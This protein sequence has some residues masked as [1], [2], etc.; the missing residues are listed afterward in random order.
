MEG[1]HISH[2]FKIVQFFNSFSILLFNLQLFLYC[3]TFATYIFTQFICHHELP[4][5]KMIDTDFCVDE[6][7]LFIEDKLDKKVE[8]NHERTRYQTVTIV[9][10]LVHRI[11]SQRCAIRNLFEDQKAVCN[12]T[13][14]DYVRS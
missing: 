7:M 13:S 8:E 14:G 5:S 11:S 3:I 10:Y 1:L 4:A 6:L 9:A 2:V 12:R